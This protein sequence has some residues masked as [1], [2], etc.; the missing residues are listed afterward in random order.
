M[1]RCCGWIPALL[2]LCACGPLEPGADGVQAIEQGLTNLT[3]QASAATFMNSAAPNARHG[4]DQTV[5]VDS[6]DSAT[7]GINDALLRFDLSQIPPNSPVLALTVVLYVTNES[8]S[9]FSTRALKRSWLES[10]V[11]WRERSANL[12]W[13]QG[14]AKGA[15]DRE[16]VNFITLGE[17]NALGSTGPK[18]ITVTA[19]SAL[20]Q[21]QRWVDAPATNFGFAIISDGVP[22]NAGLNFASNDVAVVEQRP[23]LIVT[24]GAEGAGNPACGSPPADAG[25]PAPD[26]GTAVPDAG[27][28]VPDAGTAVPDAGTAVPDAGNKPVADAG[29]SV[30]TGDPP[31]TTV[32]DAGS[33]QTPAPEVPVTS[34]PPVVHTPD[35][36]TPPQLSVK[37]W[38]CAA[39]GGEPALWA[40]LLAGVAL[41]LR[42]KA[43]RAQ[44]RRP[45]AR[46]GALLGLLL[47]AAA[48]ARAGPQRLLESADARQGAGD[49]EDALE[50]YEQALQQPSLT[51]GE[52]LRAYEG[53]G[54]CALVTRKQER[55]QWAFTRLLALSPKWMLPGWL[56][57]RPDGPDQRA[58]RFWASRE[59]PSLR[60]STPVTPVAGE[61][62][63]L[64][65]EVPSDPLSLVRGFV[66][67]WR[68]AG[69]E[70]RAEAAGPKAARLR[71]PGAE[72]QA[73]RL[74][75][76]LRAVGEHGAT[77]LEA[78]RSAQVAPAPRVAAK[79]APEPEQL[80]APS[81]AR[82]AS[83]ELEE[84]GRLSVY[85]AG[86]AQLLA[87]GFGAEVGAGWAVGRQLTLGLAVTAGAGFGAQASVRY[88]PVTFGGGR[89]NPFLQVRAG[90]TFLPSGPVFGWGA[91]LGAGVRLGPG[92][93]LG[94]VAGE[95]YTAP[96]GYMPGSVFGLLG[97]ELTFLPG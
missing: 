79:P 51:R 36:G 34:N 7:G 13:Q 52:L 81:V 46:G 90:A 4:A 22:N 30:P 83:S 61:D 45:R 59:R 24:Y 72:V 26:A 94:G 33:V 60:W 91:W 92:R 65:V 20:C 56:L 38:S 93:V 73:G 32:P 82:V 69:G 78:E 6:L 2:A 16:S 39:S 14:G 41:W 77:V 62:L 47:L 58:A 5:S 85:G 1:I 40:L 50:L 67:Q 53:V 37:G 48:P 80:P 70:G 27:T 21:V 89:V 64:S 76:T 55:A 97:Y 88:V 66:L 35:A 15:G 87:R 11:T 54:L 25:T 23:K 74:E 57:S 86:F 42:P 43:R 3:V 29:L 95:L 44:V 63:E 12:D 18:V 10:Q 96:N 75:L 8:T 17:N 84:D 68:G 19:Q 31:V 28:A 71:V 49:F 9:A